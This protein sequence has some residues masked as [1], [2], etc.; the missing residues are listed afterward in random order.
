MR[1]EKKRESEK[2][3][4]EKQEKQEQSSSLHPVL[5]DAHDD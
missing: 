4:E 3:G 1:R 2:V 5:L